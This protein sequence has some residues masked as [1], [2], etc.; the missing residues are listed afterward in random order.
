MVYLRFLTLLL[1]FLV[2][3]DVNSVNAQT[4]RTDTSDVE[5]K[6]PNIILIMADDVS[7]E[8]FGCY[9]G[10]DYETPNIDALAGA[11]VRFDHCYSTP[12]CTPS[13]V[14]IM[15]GRYS[16]R[17]YTHFG[18]LNP[19]DKTFGNLLRSAGYET[20]VAGKWQLNGLYHK[21]V[22]CDDSSRPNQAGFDEYCLWQLTKEKG[23]PDG[24]ERFW[25]P[26]LECNGHVLTSKN[27]ANLYGPDIMS[28]FVCD[29]IKRERDKPFF[30]Y[31]PTV[32]VHNPFVPTPVT[33]GDQP[34]DHSAN[35]APK[36]RTAQKA[37][38][39]AMVHYLD[40]II[41]KILRSVD[42]A[43]KL[44]NTLILFTADNGTNRAISS[45]WN[46]QKIT[47]GKG[48][49]KDMGTHVPMVAFWNGHTPVG[50][51]CSDLID[52]TDFYATFAAAAGITLADDDPIDGRSYL[53]QLNGEVGNPRDW[54]LCHYQPYWGGFKGSQYVRDERYK[55]YRDGSFYFVPNDL[56]ELNNLAKGAAGERGETAREQL[57]RVLKSVPPGPPETGGKN[58]KH[59]PT[60]PDWPAIT[61]VND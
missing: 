9:G 15:T 17:N 25:S 27:N 5:K 42:E 26:T 45:Q 48:G 10:E 19:Q 12:I 55:L 24:G 14:K 29:F 49:T 28:D 3:V 52:F 37:N 18:Y 32:L 46:G 8:C 16:F 11:G 22:G 58:A 35:K 21:A 1:Y 56:R 57:N 34:R 6:Q 61:N 33:I 39:V 20:A 36:D 4:L 53:P 41:G 50:H 30:V 40:Q 2:L 23:A 31:Y 43:G 38:F 59:R 47:G 7:W 44:E 51:V 60:Y 13:R 54:V